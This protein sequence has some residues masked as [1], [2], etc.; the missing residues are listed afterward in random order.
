VA[1]DS[2]PYVV[3]RVRTFFCRRL[4]ETVDPWQEH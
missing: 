2:Q 4:P 3:H 1:H